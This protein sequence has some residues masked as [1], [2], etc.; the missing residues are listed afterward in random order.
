MNLLPEDFSFHW[1]VDEKV[2]KYAGNYSTKTDLLVQLSDL[3]DNFEFNKY[4]AVN[5]LVDGNRA[6]A[7]VE[8]NLTSKK[9]GDSFDATLAHF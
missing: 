6:A 7:Q 9:T 4:K 5:I 2:A 8:L 1:P 3:A